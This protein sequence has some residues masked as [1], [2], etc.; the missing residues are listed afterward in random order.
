[1][2]NSFASPR[3]STVASRLKPGFRSAWLT[4]LSLYRVILRVEEWRLAIANGGDMNPKPRRARNESKAVRA[5]RALIVVVVNVRKAAGAIAVM[6]GID[7]AG[8]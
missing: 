3:P 8:G 7:A 1:M 6:R 5:Q 2:T 4:P